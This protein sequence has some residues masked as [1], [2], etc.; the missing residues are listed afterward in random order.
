ME[1]E[2]LY[3]HHGQDTNILITLI[4]LICSRSPKLLNSQPFLTVQIL[5]EVPGVGW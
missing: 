2:F 3:I 1:D 4:L 5:L